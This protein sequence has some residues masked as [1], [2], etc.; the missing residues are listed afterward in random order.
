MAAYGPMQLLVVGFDDNNFRGE[1]LPEL[2]RL[3]EHDV[4]R[5]VDLLVVSK[6]ED[7]SVAV[8]ETSDLTDEEASE[9]GAIAAEL[10]GLGEEP[11]PAPDATNFHEEVWYIA[12]T[13]APGKTA[14]VAVL[15]HRWAIPLRDAIERAG[16]EPLADA[17]LH[18][19]DLLGLGSIPGPSAG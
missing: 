17:W 6:D 18:P 12:D 10:I 1:I 19:S 14:A 4:V 11:A 8:V 16:G 13:I 2:Q 5:L 7:G 15:E 3:R 9:L